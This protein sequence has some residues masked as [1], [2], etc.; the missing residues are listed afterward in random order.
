[1]TPSKKRIDGVCTS[2]LERAL[3]KSSLLI[4]IKRSKLQYPDKLWEGMTLLVGAGTGIAPHIG[5]LK[6]LESLGVSS[7][8]NTYLYFGARHRSSEFYY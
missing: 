6:T 8:K 3:P 4:S 1:L 5:Y 7:M 2:F